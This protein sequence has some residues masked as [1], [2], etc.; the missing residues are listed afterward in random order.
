M[1]NEI[2]FN[3]IIKP[4]HPSLEGHFAGNPIA[5]GALIINYIIDGALKN[6]G[7]TYHIVSTK[8][9]KPL[10]PSIECTIYYKSQKNDVSFEIFSDEGIISKGL[11]RLSQSKS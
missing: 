2:A 4:D 10:R 8:F 1:N 7:Q 9:L 11:I 5:P 3:F 6:F